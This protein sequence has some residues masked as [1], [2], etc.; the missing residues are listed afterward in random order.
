MWVCADIISIFHEIEIAHPH[1]SYGLIGI[2][3]VSNIFYL[4]TK[5]GIYVLLKPYT[6]SLKLFWNC[7]SHQRHMFAVMA[8]FCILYSRNKSLKCLLGISRGETT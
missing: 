6:A 2:C 8:A 5:I 7:F 1:K 4:L 3:F